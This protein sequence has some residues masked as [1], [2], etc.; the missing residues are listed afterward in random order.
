MFPKSQG[1]PRKEPLPVLPMMLEKRNLTQPE[2]HAKS[3]CS[4]ESA[5]QQASVSGESEKKTRP[6]LVPSGKPGR[7][8]TTLGEF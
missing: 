4:L 3:C 5:T 6:S 8:Q 2:G 7:I 1:H